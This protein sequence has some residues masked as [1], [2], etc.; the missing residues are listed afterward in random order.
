MGQWSFEG[1]GVRC[2]SPTPE[3]EAHAKER[4]DL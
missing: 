3:L 4:G 2:W 1:W